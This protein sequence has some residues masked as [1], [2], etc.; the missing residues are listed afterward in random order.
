[1]AIPA[2]KSP[3]ALPARGKSW[4]GALSTYTAH[5]VTLVLLNNEVAIHFKNRGAL[6]PQKSARKKINTKVN[7]FLGEN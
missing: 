5:C 3:L 2:P 7:Y 4:T 6:M 1:M